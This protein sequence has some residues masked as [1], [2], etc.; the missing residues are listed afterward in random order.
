MKP[1]C[2]TYDASVDL[3]K[4]G[5]FLARTYCAAGDHV[6]WL[7]PRWEYMHYHPSIEEVELDRIGIWEEDGEIVGV[8]HPE[9]SM[10]TAYFEIDSRFEELKPEMLAYAEKN[11]SVARVGTGELEIFIN[12]RDVNFQSLAAARG[13]LRTGRS[14]AMSRFV[15]PHPF[16]K[17]PLPHGF[18]LKSL[19]EDNDLRKLN[20][21]IFRGFDHGAEPPDSGDT[22]RRFMQSAPNYRR[23]LNVV[24]ESRG[25][26]FVSYCGMW[27]EAVNRVA[28]V[29]PVCTDPD[30]RR[31]GLA[32][33]AVLEGIRRCGELGAK[34]AYVGAITLLYLCLGFRQTHTSSV[35][36]KQWR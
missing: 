35:W 20:R 12:D 31:R 8:V 27:F 13:Y 6:N 36:R 21:L 9:H 10:G 15:I 30:Y 7:Q 1:V 2:R 24:V 16:P 14:Q 5:G 28:Y 25:G 11:L 22:V 29:E 17:I 3:E 26:D 19:A 4:V 23:E 18:R 34:S 33:A 32:S